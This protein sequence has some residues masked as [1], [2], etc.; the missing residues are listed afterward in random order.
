[1]NSTL[2]ILRKELREMLTK[3]TI[4]PVVFLAALFGAMGGMIGGHAGDVV[5]KSGQE[6][7]EIIKATLKQLGK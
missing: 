2:N 1:V 5:S 7:E 4:L 3:S 6:M